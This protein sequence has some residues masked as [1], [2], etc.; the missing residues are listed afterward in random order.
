MASFV[1]EN[2]LKRKLNIYI[3]LK[4]IPYQKSRIWETPTLLTDDPFKI[5][6]KQFI[7]DF[8]DSYALLSCYE[9]II[10]HRKKRFAARQ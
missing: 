4:Y 6:A 10:E 3:F 2:D 8:K 7:G 1:T 9:V 5:Y